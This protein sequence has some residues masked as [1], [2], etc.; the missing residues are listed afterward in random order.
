MRD[1]NGTVVKWY[2]VG[3]DIEDQKAAEEALRHEVKERQRAEQLARMD[4]MRFRRFFD[5]P[6][7]GMAVTSPERRFLDVN[8]K[9]CQIVGYPRDELIGRDWASITHPD[10]LPG[11]RQ[12]I[13]REYRT[14]KC[15]R[16]CEKSVLE[17][18]HLERGLK[19]I[20][21]G[22]HRSRVFCRTEID[23]QSPILSE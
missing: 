1:E 12:S 14:E 21:K 8:E 9:L 19:F 4:E 2:S 20:K 18:D 16:K 22:A 7:I 10:D 13:C 3:I 17:F 15:E 5:L 6:L 23:L 11:R